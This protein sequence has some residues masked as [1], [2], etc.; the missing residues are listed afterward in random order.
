MK[1]YKIPKLILALLIILVTS[2]YSQTREA[3]TPD[4]VPIF[5]KKQFYQKTF[6]TEHIRKKTGHYSKTD[7]AAVIDSTW[8][9]GLPVN[10][11]LAI[12]DQFWDTID[13]DFAC[14]Q[15]IDDNWDSLRIVY[16]NEVQDTVSRGRFAAIMNHLALDLRESHTYCDDKVVNWYT[17]YDPGIPLFVVGGWGG[18][19][20]FGA[21]L[22]P[23]PDSSLLVYDAV[24][25][26]ELELVPGDIVLGYDGIPWK[27]LYEELLEAQLPLTGWWW[28]SS[29]SSYT[30]SMLMSAGMNWHLFDT[31][32]IVKF[33]TGDTIHLSTQPLIN[34][35]L[36]IFCTEQL[37]IPG[38]PKPNYNGQ[39]L[40]SYGIIDG[41]NIGY[42]YG[43]GWFWDAENEFY[44]AVYDL[45]Y[46]Y[47]T[48]GL[49][50]DFRMNYGGNMFLSNM[51]LSLL[52]NQN[53]T[54]IGFGV[55]NDPNNH[56]SMINTT[57]PS[58]Y[59]IPGDPASY[60][61]KPIA[62]L[63]GP[64]AI[65]SGDQVALR[66]KFHPNA[67]VFGKS[68]ATAFNAPTA[69]TFANPDWA[70][71][72][73][74]ADAY[75]ATNPNDYLTHD[76][77]QVDEHVWFTP[78]DVALG[79]DTVVKAATNWILSFYPFYIYFTSAY[80]SFVSPGV[81]SVL[82][83]ANI[84]NPQNYNL[85][86]STYIISADST[87]SDSLQLFDDGNHG[88]NDANDGIW[89]NYFQAPVL[90]NI[91][92]FNVTATGIDSGRVYTTSGHSQ[93]T[94][95]GPVVMQSFNIT[96][97]DTIPHHGDRLKFE[98]TLNNQGSNAPA[99]NVYSKLYSLDTCASII[100][101]IFPAYGNIAA[102]QSSTGDRGQYILFSYSCPDSIYAFFKLDIFSND[103]IFWTDTFSIFI[104]KDPLGIDPANSKIPQEFTLKQN[105]PNPFNPNTTIE[106][107]LP[108]TEFVTLKIYNILGQ[109][110]ATLVSEKLTAGKYKYKW[111]TG[112][113]AGGVYLYELKAGDFVETRKMI[114]LR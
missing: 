33:N 53:V 41:T 22:T 39:E 65:S 32:D 110:M 9:M 92:N 101:D 30:H 109:E 76:E 106:F 42:I 35:I 75:L 62:V 100:G 112:I 69:I 5:F 99:E 94:T 78:E 58:V 96:S 63:T 104:H 97:A 4:E 79:E 60:Y 70:S 107:S 37:D 17:E 87:F 13:Q 14:F 52:F 29:E 25:N 81:D 7:W 46:N 82:F 26:H 48:D 6:S 49:I 105:Y 38:V 102:G 84:E 34:Q 73:A 80:P 21:G 88:D 23:L 98:L 8:G 31:I 1:N 55:R 90:E 103:N 83:N 89:G 57:P 2:I 111:Y 45:M 86:V 10:E 36:P 54:T 66:M 44:D 95:I 19:T 20:H 72:Y 67:R 11:Q 40:F 47:Q 50:V 64:G 68:T 61:D 85:F 93:F 43:W 113:L 16:R 24:M 3:P 74:V 27:V 18:N 108:V 15:G 12:F 77:Y 71:R 59:V 56:L 91:F 51:A 28:G 114:L